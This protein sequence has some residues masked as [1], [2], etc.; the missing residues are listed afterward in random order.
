MS[1]TATKPKAERTIVSMKL[2]ATGV[3]TVLSASAESQL[4]NALELVRKLSAVAPF[5]EGAEKA[6]DGLVMVMNAK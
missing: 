6:M 2:T 3:K 5:K 1:T 4:H